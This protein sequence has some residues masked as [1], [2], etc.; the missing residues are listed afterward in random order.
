MGVVG[1]G[2]LS[3]LSEPHPTSETRNTA[4]AVAESDVLF[5]FIR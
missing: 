5:F 3:P 1:P 2:A 4:V